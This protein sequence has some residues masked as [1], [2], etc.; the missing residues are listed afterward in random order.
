MTV[1][2]ASEE[3]D[4]FD[5]PTLEIMDLACADL[6]VCAAHRYTRTNLASQLHQEWLQEAGS[7]C[8]GGRRFCPTGIAHRLL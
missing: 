5:L 6:S 3:S 4:G 8:A 2:E 7:G 1:P